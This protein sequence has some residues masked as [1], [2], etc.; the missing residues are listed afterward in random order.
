MYEGFNYIEKIYNIN[1]E[2]ET[3]P[4]DFELRISM[5]YEPID[6]QECNYIGYQ[7]NIEFGKASN[8]I[9]LFQVFDLFCKLRVYCKECDSAYHTKTTWKEFEK[10]TK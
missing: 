4:D 9:N 6:K 2:V 5:E 10:I 7:M 3:K 1:I 8:H